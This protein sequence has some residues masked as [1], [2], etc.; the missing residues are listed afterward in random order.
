MAET[1]ADQQGGTKQ[2]IPWILW[3]V[4]VAGVQEYGPLIATDS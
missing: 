1:H 2:A 4:C 3:V